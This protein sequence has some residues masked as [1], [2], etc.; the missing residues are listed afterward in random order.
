[1]IVL[2]TM[3]T[4]VLA[5][6]G[7]TVV[8]TLHQ[9][10]YLDGVVGP[11]DKALRQKVDSSP[12]YAWDDFQGT[13][14]LVHD[15]VELPLSQPDCPSAGLDG[16]GFL[17]FADPVRMFLPQTAALQFGAGFPMQHLTSIGWFPRLSPTSD[18]LRQ[19]MS[20]VF[21]PQYGHLSLRQED[22]P[23]FCLSFAFRGCLNARAHA[24]YFAE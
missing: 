18:A 1:M 8:E 7:P 9:I 11:D 2:G 12:L 24:V 21:Q 14:A 10:E 6:E 4:Y 16:L 17:S 22:L 5:K 20:I 23:A 19:G 15:S 3:A 13:A